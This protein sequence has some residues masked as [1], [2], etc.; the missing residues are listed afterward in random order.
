MPGEL[1]QLVTR[2]LAGEPLEAVLG[3][4]AFAGHRVQVDPGVFVPRVR[5]E[6]LAEQALLETSRGAVVVELC[7]GTGAV[8]LVVAAAGVAAHVHAADVDP[9]AVACAARNLAPYAA[10]AH[11]GDLWAAL[12]EA[13]RGRVDVLVANAP[14]VPTSDIALM[15][16]EA[17]D[18]EP[19][20][21]LDG[22]AD[23][24]DVQRR[25]AAAAPGWLA[26]GGH[27]IIETSER[28]APLTA[29]AVAAAGLTPRVER[30]DDLDGTA[31]VGVLR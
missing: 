30:D 20:V 13:L 14:Y 18:H 26:P 5:T 17:R 11:L 19:A 3:W 25:V 23:G 12:P 9:R 27:L 8:A 16:P 21:A 7:C 6:L 28:Q 2:R 24:L 10:S 29:A 22:G 15:P 31:V 4:A 1:E